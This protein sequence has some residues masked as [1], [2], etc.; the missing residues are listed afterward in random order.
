MAQTCTNSN[1]APTKDYVFELSNLCT[2]GIIVNT[3]FACSGAN[4][5]GTSVSATPWPC[6]PQ[7][8]ETVYTCQEIVEAS[9]DL[10]SFG[11]TSAASCTFDGPDATWSS[12]YGD[13]R[14]CPTITNQILE[15]PDQTLYA[16]ASLNCTKTSWDP[17]YKKDCCLGNIPSSDI[18]CDPR[19]CLDDPQGE[20]AFVYADMCNSV[21]SCGK[22][23]L[24]T[25]DPNL[26]NGIACNKWY[27]N[28]L[29]TVYAAQDDP[30]QKASVSSNPSFLAIVEMID[31]YCKANPSAGECTCYN[32]HKLCSS[33]VTS[34][35]QSQCI[36]VDPTG[37]SNGSGRRM[38]AYCT[39][40]GGSSNPADPAYA[41]A[42]GGS[43]AGSTINPSY[44]S[45]TINDPSSFLPPGSDIQALPTHCWLPACQNSELTCVF[46]NMPDLFTQCPSVCFQ[47]SSGANI[48][49]NNSNVSAMDINIG[50]N[51]LACTFEGYSALCTPFA[52]PYGCSDL[53]VN[54][55]INQAA[56]AFTVRVY[57][58]AQ[59]KNPTF[60]SFSYEAFTG[61]PTQLQI[62]GGTNK[63][64][65]NG[66]A[67]VDLQLQLNTQNA[68]ANEVVRTFIAVLDASGV[69]GTANLPVTILM[70]PEGTP[71]TM[72][73]AC[74]TGAAP[75]A[76][77]GGGGG[78]GSGSSGG[79]S[80]SSSSNCAS[81]SKATAQAKQ[82]EFMRK[83]TQEVR[84][85]ET[86]GA[87]TSLHYKAQQKTSL[88]PWSI[89]AI[90]IAALLLLGVLAA[91]FRKQL[92][93]VFRKRALF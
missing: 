81:S 1:A 13:T 22:H 82:D 62:V 90:V 71:L 34:Q 42:C 93:Q 41:A 6:K 65:L 86:Y 80:G 23:A 4:I 45:P 67:Y 16:C 57:N 87:P 48:D 10:G 31:G 32:A 30:A 58:V 15:V 79:S 78:G 5:V 72:T 74:S 37:L 39:G 50:N 11:C 84:K 69:N 29:N 54:A 76:P 75:S 43:A 70:T 63:G 91:L 24:L 3:C 18:R 25:Q 64:S 77:S 55:P 12:T 46:K 89:A 61:L 7:S 27:Q 38:D 17:T 36:I 92:V 59:D 26:T 9:G 53:V 49:I 73:S 40:V 66:G 21:T 47:Y 33:S 51:V 56:L 85:R 35:N 88:K 20:C 52:F 83:H 14:D 44:T 60:N 19:W 2:P 8:N 68:Y 28:V